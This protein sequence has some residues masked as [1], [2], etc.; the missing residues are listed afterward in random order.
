M[1]RGGA[2]ILIVL[3]MAVSIIA[4]AVAATD[5]PATHVGDTPAAHGM[6]YESVTLT[7]ADGVALAAWYLE[8]SNGAGVV[9][10][11]G[12]GSTRSDVL[13]QSAVLVDSGYA[14]LAID[15]RGHG[16]SHGTAMD[17]GW[18]GDLD[19]AAG[20]AFLGARPW[21]RPGSDRCRR[22]LDAGRGGHRRSG[23]RSVDPCHGRRGATARRAADKD[24]LSEAYG[25]RGWIQELLER[26]QDGVTGFFADASPPISLRSAVHG[27]Q[28]TRFLLITAGKVVD[29]RHAA[30]FIQSG[31]DERVTVWNVEG[32]DHTGGYD[33]QPEAWKSNV[34]EFLDESLR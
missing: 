20:T 23:H 17:F 21:D 18:Y 26:A 12:A 22:V 34:V 10:V 3:A 33:T 28:D 7:T 4:P 13:D 16:D 8:G 1:W 9:V 11:H 27:A 29:E 15:S 30:S 31:A 24:W 19:I 14:V 25:L 2:G 6:D 5:V 32:A